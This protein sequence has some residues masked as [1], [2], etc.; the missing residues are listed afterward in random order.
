M[1]SNF[2]VNIGVDI[3][4][5]NSRLKAVEQALSSIS[6]S[7]NTA[8]S[9][10]KSS[11]DS[12]TSSVQ[13]VGMDMNR[14]RLATFAFGQVIRDAGFFSQSFGLG[15]LAISNNIPILIDQ[16][17]LLSGVSAGFGSVLSV[18][19]SLLAAGATVF[20]YWAQGVERDGGSVSGAIRKMGDDSESAIGKLINYLNTPPASEMLGKAVAGLEEGI[21]TISQIMKAG[22]DLIIAIWDSFGTDISAVLGVFYEIASNQFNNVLNIVRFA[23]SVIKGDFTGAFEAILNIGKNVL[24][25]LIGLI[26]NFVRISSTLLGAIVGAIDPLKGEIIKNAGRELFAFGEGLKFVSSNTEETTFSFK[27]FF[28]DL[29]KVGNQAGKTGKE[30]DKLNKIIKEPNLPKGLYGRDTLNEYRKLIFQPI[31]GKEVKQVD[32]VPKKKLGIYEMEQLENFVLYMREVEAQIDDIFTNGIAMTIG[33]A[34]M[35]IGEAFA[36]GGNIGKA[37]GT[38][39][40]GTLSSVL[41]QFADKLIAASLAGLTFSKALKGLFDPKNWALALA[42]GVALKVAAG[43]LSGFSRNPTSGA[44]NVTQTSSRSGGGFNSMGMGPIYNRPTITGIGLSSETQPVLETR[45]SGN[46]LVILMNR[47]NKNRNGYY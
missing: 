10:I 4:E 31:K 47:A 12:A 8:G 22:V 38:A 44:A 33:N 25:S 39:I 2:K 23:S 17:V 3:T 16:L 18:L 19:G 43:A 46:D 20:A 15:V 21:S 13:K 37:F 26:Q 5:L 32:L 40:L 28:N 24:N 34:M 45:V 35:A 36:T 1:D 30:I 9:S 27:D 6:S 42:A 29:F 41:S 14:A 11:F 7:A